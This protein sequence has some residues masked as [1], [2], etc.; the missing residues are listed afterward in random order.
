M[1]ITDP[2]I[3]SQLGDY[4]IVDILG[5]GGMA[6]VYRGYDPKLERYAAVKVI[7]AY[8]TSESE[9][10]YRQ[11]FQREARA[12]AKLNHPR[13]VGVYQFGQKDTLYYMAMA[14]IDGRD[15]GQILKEYAQQGKM[16]SVRDVV[17]V[18]RDVAGALDHAHAGGVI[19]RDVKPSNIMI[20]A[21]GHAVLTDFGLAL[22]VPEGS[23]GNTFGSAH[24]IAPEQAIS[25]AN[26]VPQSDFYSLGIVLY[27]MLVGKVPFDDPS[28]MSVALKH[29][30][31]PPPPP[32]LY[33]PSVSPEV[34]AV[35]LKMLEKEPSKRF[36]NSDAFMRALEAAVNTSN[37]TG[38]SIGRGGANELARVVAS[39]PNLSSTSPQ[40][41]ST[42]ISKARP[43]RP[44]RASEG[45]GRGA[46]VAVVAV[47]LLAGAV[48]A[49]LMLNPSVLGGTTT[50]T[51]IADAGSG[52]ETVE[53]AGAEATETEEVTATRRTA[54]TRRVTATEE[55]D[56]TERATATESTR[57][58][59]AGGADETETPDADSTDTPASMVRPSQTQTEEA[60]TPT[61][62]RTEPSSR[63]PAE[64]ASPTERATRAPD[65]TATEATQA[66]AVAASPSSERGIIIII[67]ND[68]EVLIINRTERPINLRNVQF[69]QEVE[70]GSPL[71]F[72]A[73]F[74]SGIDALQPGSCFQVF[75]NTQDVRP[76]PRNCGERQGWQAVSFVRLF[77][78]SEDPDATFKVERFNNVLGECEIDAG[79]CEVDVE[80]DA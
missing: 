30:S 75:Q 78:K 73:N 38:D 43:P 29:L 20:T 8:L 24:Y 45:R 25:S 1:S 2:L 31:D 27:Q 42:H 35:I 72:N 74:L 58:A 53:A 40:Q 57:S 63:T 3:G 11:R 33:N 61:A 77:W 51:A 44:I 12:I 48:A 16:M 15:L 80:P 19:H 79:V 41:P 34:E 37:P 13:I 23:I 7:D 22:S 6:R 65:S 76:V 66:V 71:A 10:E 17:R 70:G 54:A 59:I 26:A 62:T 49:F 47:L 18:M 39:Q 68:D 4:R 52:R 28:A 32:R 36:E 55:H 5:R 9:E 60:E 67:Y 14:F 50:P 69:V 46:W 64:G 21:D 56:A